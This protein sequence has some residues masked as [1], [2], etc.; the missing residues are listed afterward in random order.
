MHVLARSGWYLAGRAWISNCGIKTCHT[1]A[2]GSFVRGNL[3]IR[4]IQGL[5]GEINCG[6]AWRSVTLFSNQIPEVNVVVISRGDQDDRGSETESGHVTQR[7]PRCES[8][9]RTRF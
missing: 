3:P 5:E 2:Q 1:R 4:S 9:N 6:A 7:G 8:L